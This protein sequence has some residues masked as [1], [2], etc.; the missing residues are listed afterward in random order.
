MN[1]IPDTAINLTSGD[2]GRDWLN[3]QRYVDA[4]SSCIEDSKGEAPICIGLFGQWGCGKSSVVQTYKSTHAETQVFIYDAWKYSGDS[5]RR[6]FLMQLGKELLGSDF[7][8]EKTLTTFYANETK[9][10]KVTS[11][12]NAVRYDII[13]QILSVAIVVVLIL[14]LILQ[15]SSFDAPITFTS[16]TQILTLAMLIYMHVKDDLKTSVQTPHMFAP[17][18]FGQY[19]HDMLNKARTNN[20]LTRHLVIVIDNLDRCQPEVAYRMLSDIKSFL[21]NDNQ[22]TFVIPVDAQ[23]LEKGI[24][25]FKAKDSHEQQVQAKEFLRKLFNVSITF[26]PFYVDEVDD[27]AQK[28]NQHYQLGYK[29][30]TIGLVSNM[31]VGNPRRI[32]QLFNNLKAEMLLHEQA[33]EHETMI[34]HLMILSEE[35]PSFYSQVVNDTTVLF[36]QPDL[37]KADTS[38][39]D[40]DK[41][42][43]SK[44]RDVHL[45]TY[46]RLS[47]GLVANY[48]EKVEDVRRLLSNSARFA[49]IPLDVRTLVI[50][51]D[52]KKLLETYKGKD[53][54]ALQ[55]YLYF[56]FKTAITLQQYDTSVRTLFHVYFALNAANL[57]TDKS[58]GQL[59]KLLLRD[60][61]LLHLSIGIA[62]IRSAIDLGKKLESHQCS[63]LTD[64]I[65]ALCQY[66]TTNLVGDNVPWGK[67]ISA[68]DFFYGCSVWTKEQ[69]TPLVIHFAELYKTD[70]ALALKYDYK[71]NAQELFTESLM[72]DM[73]ST[74]DYGK[75]ETIDVLT[76]SI[77]Q[78][79]LKQMAAAANFDAFLVALAAN[80]SIP[81]FDLTPD[82]HSNNT[83]AVRPLVQQ[84]VHF[85]R[86][87]PKGYLKGAT[88]GI[89]QL[90]EKVCHVI[91]TPG[92]GNKA[93]NHSYVLD[94]L[95]DNDI[96]SEFL[97]YFYSVS[98]ATD[99]SVVGK[100]V[101]Q[102]LVDNKQTKPQFLDKA[103]ELLS[104]GYDPKNYLTF[105]LTH[106]LEQEVIARLGVKS[107]FAR[108]I[109]VQLAKKPKQ[110]LAELVP[111]DSPSASAA[112]AGVREALDELF[113][114]KI[115]KKSNSIS[116]SEF[117]LTT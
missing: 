67:S 73:A 88:K 114:L 78:I 30:D 14:T 74:I 15:L 40:K 108:T 97:N 86:N 37:S 29:P 58:V 115:V 89:R 72:R 21:D 32:I 60:T 112:K 57:L 69:I 16:V 111:S 63:G 52:T 62:D 68:D 104:A 5:F 50:Q 100:D 2:E 26:K 85:Y 79:S 92:P 27:F 47:Q 22:T 65:I 80:K 4:L 55:E 99:E 87:W 13:T 3:T 36:A 75:S 91:G 10:T 59:A 48:S 103:K 76:G 24:L 25:E 109:I 34:C 31:Y 35:F 106:G 96:I 45:D 94:N 117:M 46:L 90:N 38:L 77:V 42:T 116:Q 70:M 8:I 6:T 53:T 105:F 98:L 102:G 23:A 1:F 93:I 66:D 11:V 12:I 61:G 54:S 71:D 19:Y 18:Q 113:T 51:A 17:E 43:I 56:R 7:D 81:R 84:L 83:T 39:E 64:R 101:L 9:D 107:P 20:K 41:A 82:P 28:L 95:C 110:T 44:K 33:S 49:S